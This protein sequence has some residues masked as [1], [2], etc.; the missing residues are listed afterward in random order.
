MPGWRDPLHHAWLTPNLDLDEEDNQYCLHIEAPGVEAD[1]VDIH[2]EGRDLVLSGEVHSPHAGDEPNQPK[3]RVQE[4]YFGR[5]YREISLPRD[6]DLEHITA[7][8]N[9]GVLQ[10]TV[11]KKSE[12][13]RR[14]IPVNAGK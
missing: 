1:D 8:L 10:I 11:P 13:E 5:F 6:A 7:S 2:V 12:P 3:S 14:Q 4:R 9:Q